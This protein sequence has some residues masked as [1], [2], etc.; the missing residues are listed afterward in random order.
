MV[1]YVQFSLAKKQALALLL[2][3]IYFLHGHLE[4]EVYMKQ[5]PGFVAQRMFGRACQLYQFIYGLKQSQQA[6]FERFG[7]IVQQFGMTRSK[8]NYSLFYMTIFQSLHL[9]T[10]LCRC[11]HHHRRWSRWNLSTS[12]TLGLKIDI[13]ITQRKYALDKLEEVGYAGL[14]TDWYSHGS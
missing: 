14:Q 6:W 9:P 11:Y 13:V 10:C 3:K 12:T 7:S 4:E 5:P 8:T 2:I 1:A